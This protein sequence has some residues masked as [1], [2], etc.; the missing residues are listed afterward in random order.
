[1]PATLR[2]SCAPV[3][4]APVAC[5]LLLLSTACGGTPGPARGPE[6][7]FEA[8]PIPHAVSAWIR[9]R[10]AGEVASASFTIR[11]KPGHRARDVHVVRS[12]AALERSGAIDTPGRRI[13][14]DVFGLYA[15]HENHV[16]FQV[17][18]NDGR[19][20]TWEQELR[21]PPASPDA[22][23]PRIDVWFADARLDM[24]YMILQG[25]GRPTI[26]DVDGEIRWRAPDVGEAVFP[27]AITPDGLVL[28]SLFSPLVCRVDWAGRAQSSALSDPRC[29]LSHH[30]IE[31][32]KR[33]FLN[34]VSY[35]DGD[36]MRPQSVLAEMEADGEI[37]RLWDFDALFEDLI[38]SHG[39]DPSPLVQNGVDWFHMNSAVYDASDDS[40]I[41]SSRENFVVKADYATGAIRWI[42]GNPD[43]LW[44]AAYPASLQPLALEIVGDPPIGQHSL[45]VHP[46]GTRLLLFDNG[47]GNIVLDDVGD[48][49]ATSRVAMYR[50]DEVARTA[51]E[52]WRFDPGIFSAFCSSAYGTRSG[53]VLA[54]Y[55]N[56]DGN[57]PARFLVV[58]EAQ[59]VLFDAALQ[60][61][62]CG[63][64]YSAQELH[65]EDLRV[66]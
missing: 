59:E 5:I 9:V 32:G 45:S 37:T 46:D 61:G 8:S 66:D 62:G 13:R 7:T 25:H 51:T 36:V 15:G 41:V 48:T 26:L 40:V 17:E 27:R 42:L 39:E 52:V 35:M 43:K 33:G 55:S 20:L 4:S 64:A 60:S 56:P 16:T 54:V 11:S 28:G 30:N 49:R 1:M 12:R 21:T 24:D 29:V 6:V 14:V 22:T 2:G 50:I 44:Y 38:G 58:N 53:S 18:L 23:A 63:L 57:D 3:P 47:K 31:P 10:D 19:S 65:L 34:T